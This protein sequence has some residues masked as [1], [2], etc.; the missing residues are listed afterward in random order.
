MGL[1]LL[2]GQGRESPTVIKELL[3]V[4]TNPRKPQYTMALDVPL[5]LFHC[6]YDVDKDWVYDEEELRTVI[7]HLQSDWTMHSV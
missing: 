5:N 4:E 1:L 6:T 2:I 3:D 7:A